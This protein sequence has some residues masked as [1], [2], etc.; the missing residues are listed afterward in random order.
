MAKK[1]PKK[2]ESSDDA[3][4]VA[5]KEPR[6]ASR[7]SVGSG[8]GRKGAG[9][10]YPSIDPATVTGKQL[11]IV[12]SPSKA[13]T[14]NKYLGPG[15]VV[16]ASVGHVRDLPSRNPKGDKSPVPGVDLEKDFAPTYEIVPGKTKTIT[17]LK[18][19]AKNASHI[20]FATDLDRE[21]EAIAW[22][23]ADELGIDP[24]K[25]KR[26]IFAAITKEDIKHAFENPHPIDMDRVNAQQ[27]RRI[28]DRVVGYQVSPLLWKKVARGLSA[29]RV[30][31][32]AVRLV[33]DRERAKSAAS[34]PMSSGTSPPTSPSPTPR[35]RQT[36]ST[37]VDRLHRSEKGREG[38]R[39]RPAKPRLQ[40]AQRSQGDPGRTGR[41]GGGGREVRTRLPRQGQDR[42]LISHAQGPRR[43]PTRRPHED[44]RHRHARG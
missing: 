39:P 10:E 41:G 11:V 9:R 20:W 23:L 14:I 4:G 35:P 21:G 38:Q 42:P 25:A 31:S 7:G 28:L 1:T 44:H 29:G 3:G 8:R 36:R 15:Y 16:L 32:V 33:V 6:R 24:A 40:L 12:E 13:K 22:H 19:A 34:S 17:D 30:Q 27:A 43:R 5:V 26:V 37:A 18:R 2:S